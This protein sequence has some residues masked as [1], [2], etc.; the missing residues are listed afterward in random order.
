GNHQS[1]FVLENTNGTTFDLLNLATLSDTD[2]SKFDPNNSG[3]A[4][5]YF[6]NNT[7]QSVLILDDQTTSGTARFVLSGLGGTK[8]LTPNGDLTQADLNDLFKREQ[9]KTAREEKNLVFF[10]E[11]YHHTGTTRNRRQKDHHTQ[12][13]FRYDFGYSDSV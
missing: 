11:I 5:D 9:T 12:M 1:V 7:S 6:E 10:G 4:L 8:I 2:V 13:V 3:Y